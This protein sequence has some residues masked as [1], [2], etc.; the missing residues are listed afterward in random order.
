MTFVH[1]IRRR[2]ALRALQGLDLGI[3]CVAT[4]YV[5]YLDVQAA[6]KNFPTLSWALVGWLVASL[7]VWHLALAGAKLYRSHRLSGG[8]PVVEILSGVSMGAV[9][10]GAVTLLFR[11][12]SIDLNNILH[13]W[14]ISALAISLSRIL[15]WALLVSLRYRGRNLRFALVVGSGPRAARLIKRICERPTGYR[16]IGYVDDLALTD[17]GYLPGIEC[18]GMVDTLPKILAERVVDEVFIAL[19]MRS[20]YDAT[21]QV[22]RHCEEQG[23]PVR[24]PCDLFVPGTCAQYMDVIEDMTVI[25]LVPSAPPSSYFISKRIIDLIVS[26]PLLV[27][28]APLFIVVAILIKLDSPGPVFFVQKRVGLNK[29]L[30]PLI[31][32]RTMRQ[33]SEVMQSQFEYLNESGGPVFKI[34]DDPRVTR[35]GRFL[36]RQ[37]IDELPQLLNVLVGHMSLVGPRPLPLRDVEGFQLDWQRRRFSARPG[38]TCLWQISGRS[39][40]SLD[41]WMHLDMLYMDSRSLFLDLKILVQTIPAVLQKTGAY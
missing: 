15:L 6:D 5:L 27:L 1:V 40:I 8:F 23:V 20:F 12:A 11:P 24:I 3:L 37:S 39:S 26:V 9:G 28:F 25:S 34:R 35:L 38:I 30:F 13:V 41:Q 22:I 4:G 7:T 19:P 14:W 17:S 33:D 2:L 10:I 31:K 29:R 32:F 36:R 16:M 21:M 18:L